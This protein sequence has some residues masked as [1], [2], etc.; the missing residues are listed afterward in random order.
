MQNIQLKSSQLQWVNLR[1]SCDKK[2]KRKVSV[3]Q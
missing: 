1:Q 2:V 3:L